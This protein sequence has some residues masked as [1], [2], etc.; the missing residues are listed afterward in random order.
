VISFFQW[1]KSILGGLL[2]SFLRAPEQNQDIF[3]RF[4]DVAFEI[5]NNRSTVMTIITKILSS[6]H[7]LVCRWEFVV[8]K[9][10]PLEN[11][12]Y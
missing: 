12:P 4:R 7:L 10:A 6:P 8:D 1:G 5:Y 2:F 3:P 9:F 11:S